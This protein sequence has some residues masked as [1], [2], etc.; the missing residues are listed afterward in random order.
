[1]KV[2]FRTD[3]SLDI[4]SGHVMRCLT[5]ANALREKGSSASF[6]CRDHP[7]HLL[8][9]I[10]SNGHE[11]MMLPSV[12]I[13]TSSKSGS[14]YERW[15][16]T[17]WQTDA[18][19]VLSVIGGTTF[20]WMIVDHYAIDINWEQAMRPAYDRL[21]VIDDLANR[22]HDCAVL[23]DQTFGRNP[24]DYLGWV[25]GDCQLLCGSEYALLR[26]E[27]ARLREYSL[28]RR[29]PP[30]LS[31]L[32]ITMG[33]VDKD[34]VTG[35]ILSALKTTALPGHCAIKVVL[36][37]TSPWQLEIERLA[38]EMPWKTDVLVGVSNMGQ[39][40]ADRDLAIGAAG[41]TSWER[42]CLGLPTIMLVLAD[43]QSKVAEGLSRTGAVR[44]I[45]GHLNLHHALNSLIDSL[46]AS[47][48]ELSAMSHAALAIVDG[49]GIDAVMVKLER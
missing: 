33:G 48:D 5:L 22:H 37:S 40:M 30:Q 16:G 14:D 29:A 49:H 34:N 1:M 32:L 42:C 7:G 8:D 3:A 39:L 38:C 23:L 24:S 31:Q 28:R 20:D 27:F 4:G 46:C 19:Q 12:Q 10:K 15:L 11:V 18:E 2:A 44:I 25:S 41:A 35:Q 47:L 6:I 36:G 17:G 45:E 9:L 43:N 21:M 26:P 13:Q